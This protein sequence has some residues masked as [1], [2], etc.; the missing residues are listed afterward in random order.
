MIGNAGPLTLICPRCRGLDANGQLRTAPLTTLGGAEAVVGELSE[1]SELRCSGCTAR[2]PVVEGIAV[3]FPHPGELTHAHNPPW[4]PLDLGADRLVALL[5]GVTET[6]LA[7]LCARLGRYL[8]S[9]FHDWLAE[10]DAPIDVPVHGRQVTA[11]LRASERPELLAVLG[12]AVGREAYEVGTRPVLL[13]DAHLPSLLA[14]KRLSEKRRLDF[15]LPQEAGRWEATALSVPDGLKSPDLRL[16]CCDLTDPPLL[17][18]CLPEVLMP[19]VIDSVAD[20]YMVLGQCLA[21]R[22]RGGGLTLTTPF[23]WRTEVTTVAKRL[24][25]LVGEGTSHE[26]LLRLVS[27]LDPEATLV[28][29]DEFTWGIWGTRRELTVY[30]ST[31]YRFV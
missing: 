19:N 3:V 18:G 4:L 22:Q 15:V 23:A 26:A 21:L 5:S 6:P 12:A 1:V 9:G 2:Y 25:T 28:D 8:W 31:A 17:A 11:W 24:A 13:V 14:A 27:E 10:Q 29:Q 7:E 20:P 16:L 30:R